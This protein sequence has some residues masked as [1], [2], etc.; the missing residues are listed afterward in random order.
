MTGS[1]PEEEPVPADALTVHREPDAAEED[2]EENLSELHNSQLGR[3]RIRN[4]PIEI[5]TS[6]AA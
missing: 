3:S 2:E 1:C 5:V 6:T 4:R